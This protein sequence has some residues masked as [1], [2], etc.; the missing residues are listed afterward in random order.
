[1]ILTFNALKKNKTAKA[2]PQT[3]VSSPD[4]LGLVVEARWQNLYIFCQAI[5][6]PH[7]LLLFFYN[8]KEAFFS[9]DKN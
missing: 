1:M 4:L 7:F 8:Y 9:L 5:K 3:G 6:I 2:P